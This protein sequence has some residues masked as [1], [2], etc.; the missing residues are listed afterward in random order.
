[1]ADCLDSVGENLEAPFV[2]G[3]LIADNTNV[4]GEDLDSLFEI[5]EVG[6]DGIDATLFST[7]DLVD[8]RGQRNK[9]QHR[10]KNCEP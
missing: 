8:A 4:I 3:V 7:V 5:S 9:Y 2:G 6:R 10:E 1:M